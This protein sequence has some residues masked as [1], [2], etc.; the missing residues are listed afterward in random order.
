MRPLDKTLAEANSDYPADA[1]TVIVV[2]DEALTEYFEGTDTT[3][4]ATESIRSR[5]TVL[6][7]NSHPRAPDRKRGRRIQVSA[8]HELVSCW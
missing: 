1:Q 4:G 6:Q 5:Y 3:G 8:S 2:F 7:L